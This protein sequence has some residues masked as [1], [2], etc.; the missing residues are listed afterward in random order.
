MIWACNSG[1]EQN[2]LISLGLVIFASQ[3]LLSKLIKFFLEFLLIDLKV[4]L[5]TEIPR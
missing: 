4:P 3:D 5:Q 2:V 1:S